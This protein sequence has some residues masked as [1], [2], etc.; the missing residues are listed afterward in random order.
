[1]KFQVL[2]HQQRSPEWF[3][4]R[5]GRL[6]GSC[7]AAVLAKGKGG[8]ESVVRRDY[9]LQ[10]ACERLT[11]LPQEGG[12]VNAEMQRGIDL[13][14]VAF[15]AYEALTGNVARSTGFL[16]AEEHMVGCSL[17]GDVN[18]FEI[19][20]EL[21]CPKTATHLGYLRN[22]Q[23]LVDAYAHQV[24]HNLWVTGAKWCDL[25]TFDDRLPK[26]LRIGL[27]KVVV[28]EGDLRIYEAEALK[29][30]AEVDSEVETLKALAAA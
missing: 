10:L 14:P 8:A 24:R 16:S 13:E 21:K 2:N 20:L 1:M 5:A 17:D 22:P 25:V 30:L 3:A 26:P 19:I 28:S 4:A 27:V 11:G 9:R 29:F 18:N 7:A 23:S 6:T 12:F 15:A